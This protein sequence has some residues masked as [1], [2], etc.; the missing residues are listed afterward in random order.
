MKVAARACG[1]GITYL[2][3]VPILHPCM[4]WGPYTWHSSPSV[5]SQLFLASSVWALVEVQ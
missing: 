1:K 2:C 3:L 4:D 5:P